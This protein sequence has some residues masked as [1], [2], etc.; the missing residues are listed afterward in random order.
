VAMIMRVIPLELKVLF[1]KLR[2][3][4]L[5]SDGFLGKNLASNF[6]CYGFI[7]LRV[8]RLIITFG[9]GNE[10]DRLKKTIEDFSPDVIINALGGIDNHLEASG[11]SIFNS[12]FL[13]TLTLFDY[14]R[15]TEIEKPIKVLTF[16][17]EAEGQPRRKYPIYAALK[18][19]EANLVMT[20]SEYFGNSSIHWLRVKLPRLNGGLGLVGIPF[21]Q[22]SE[23][24]GFK[25]VWE[26]VRV[27]LGIDETHGENDG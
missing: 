11:T 10:H 4:I 17:S 23:Y 12:I 16:G 6:E 15:T 9:D 27:A 19:A 3:I 24:E 7:V 5:G 20:A 1:I 21:G 13:P 14:F 2:V 26:K 25:F 22:P 18:T 8:N